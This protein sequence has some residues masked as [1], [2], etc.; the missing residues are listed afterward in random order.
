MHLLSEEKCFTGE[1]Y[2]V[3]VQPFSDYK[4]ERSAMH[5][6]Y[7][8]IAE[9]LICSVIGARMVHL[10]FCDSR[11]PGISTTTALIHHCNENP[12]LVNNMQTLVQRNFTASCK[13]FS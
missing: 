2:R 3:V 6:H 8:L 9:E 7:M 4:K 10:T 11:Y 12:A 5:L 1:S 13:D